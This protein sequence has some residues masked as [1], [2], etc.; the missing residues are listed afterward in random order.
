MERLLRKDEVAAF[1]ATLAPHQIATLEDGST[2]RL[3]LLAHARSSGLQ[4]RSPAACRPAAVRLAACSPVAVNPAALWPRAVQVLER[5]V[6]EHN[7]LAASK[8]YNNISFEQLGALLGIDAAKA[9]R[10]AS[11]MLVEQRLQG[12]IDQVE[13]LIHFASDSRSDALHAFDTQIEHIC[14]SVETIA[15]AITKKQLPQLVAS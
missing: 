12:S 9:E 11:A 6:I 8:L 3:H 2:V 5:A 10:M 15:G 14:R 13:Q 4:P 7:M 1:A